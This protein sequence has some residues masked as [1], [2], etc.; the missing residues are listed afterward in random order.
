M[1]PDAFIRR[2]RGL[3]GP[4]G[5]GIRIFPQEYTTMLLI[6]PFGGFLVLGCIIAAMQYFQNRAKAKAGEEERELE[7][8]AQRARESQMLRMRSRRLR[9]E[10]DF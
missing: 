7:E 8:Q 3:L 1:L 5:A 2:M 6:L 10:I 4:E 9:S